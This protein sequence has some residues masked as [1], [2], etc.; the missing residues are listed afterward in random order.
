MGEWKKKPL[1]EVCTLQRGFDLPKR[2][3]KLGSFP[4]V[5]SSGCID[6][7]AE[8]KVTHPGVVTG[9]S[10]SIGS[11]FF[12]E[13]DFWPLNTTLYVKDFHGNVPRFIFH[14]LGS[15]DLKRFASG[16]G[17]P[18]LNRNNVH[19]EHVCVP[20]S[21]PE[22]KRIV[23]ILDEAFAAIA[24]ATANAEKNLA[25]ARELF[26][27][28]LN[29]VFSQKGD[30]WVE[31]TLG[32]CLSVQ[33]RNGWSPPAA[34]HSDSGVPVLTL[35]S[36]T[37]FQFKGDKVKFTSAPSDPE[38]HYWVKD[39]D[40]LI[41]RSNTPELVGHVAIAH[42]ITK[43][44]IYPDL[45]MRMNT[46]ESLLLTEFLY[47][48]MRT[49]RLRDEIMGRAQ[50]ANPT[51]KKIN[52]GSVQT[53]PI[54]LPTFEIQQVI[55]EKLDELSQETKNL[56]EVQQRKLTLLTQLKQSILQKA[57]SGELTADA[58]VGERTLS[59]AGV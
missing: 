11:V 23:A 34:H 33:P 9:R 12:I 2:L 59:E 53:L 7:H 27:S 54:S 52:K 31:T 22:Q 32:A 26:E 36:V 3:R 28:E 25:N 1:G 47:Y 10:G 48:Q 44:T 16:A 40:F 21:L 49:L 58:K 8:A 55:V 14:L 15:L 46:D 38:R 5:S 29:R 37:G 19:C 41:T 6:S 24:T 45:I 35:S 42:G 50:G 13:D 18:T 57:F 30:G 17:V 56:E 51:M 39:G 43:P 4:L 20:A